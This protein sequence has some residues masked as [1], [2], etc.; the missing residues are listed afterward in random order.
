LVLC[1]TL[2]LVANL[3]YDLIH[4][5]RAI[6]QGE[7]PAVH[8]DAAVASRLTALGLEPGNAVGSIGFTYSAYWARLGGWQVVAEIPQR[9]RSTFFKATPTTQ[10]KVFDAFR[11]AGAQAIVCSG[12]EIEGLGWQTVPG[13]GFA[14]Y[15]LRSTRDQPDNVRLAATSR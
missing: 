7:S 3:G 10:A 13:T 15:D 12:A 2:P 6:Q 9:E 1:L 14:I 4:L 8:P 5:S 11:Q